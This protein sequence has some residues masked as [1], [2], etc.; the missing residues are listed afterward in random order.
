V[1]EVR[2][3]LSH[4]PTLATRNRKRLETAVPDFEHAPPIW[5]LRVGDYRVFYDVDGANEVVL[6][7]AVR[8]KQQ[9]QTTED[10]IHEGSDS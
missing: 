6:V 7:R 8:R 10:I 4:Q 1:D 2:G 9:G 3:Q 5:E